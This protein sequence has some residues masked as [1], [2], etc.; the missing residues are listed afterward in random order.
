VAVTSTLFLFFVESRLGAPGWEGPLLL[1]FF[2]SAA[3]STPLWSAA[4][5]RYGAKPMLLAGMVL[6]VAGLRL[7]RHARHRRPVAFAVICIASGAALGADLTLLPAIF[8]RRLATI[9]P[10]GGRASGCGPSCRSSRW[11]SWRSS[12]CPSCRRAA[13]PGGLTNPP[14]ALAMLTLLYALFPVP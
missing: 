14:E 5:Q 4:A 8:A 6:S 7:R 10:G 12:S 11:P 2:L 3:A 13:L 1:L 9:A